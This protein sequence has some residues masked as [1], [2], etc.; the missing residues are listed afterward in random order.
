MNPESEFLLLNELYRKAYAKEVS[1]FH[2]LKSHGSDRGIFRIIS[3]DGNSCIGIINSYVDENKAFI[4]FA[5]HFKT[6][7]LNVPEVF[8]VSDDYKSYLIEDLGD[9]TLLHAL[10]RGFDEHIVSLYQQVMDELVRF[11]I[12]ASCGIDYSLCYQFKE[13]GREN[14]YYDLNYFRQAF[15]DNFRIKYNNELL[16][17]DFNTLISYLLNF[18]RSYFL[19]RDFQSR[20][21]MIKNNSPYFIDFQ[22]GRQGAFLYDIAS[23]IYDAKA[24]IPQQM[25]ERFIEYYLEKVSERIKI[26]IDSCHRGF[27]Y[28][29]FIRIMQA[30]GAYGYLG[31]VKGKREFLESVPKA[32]LNVRCLLSDRI[33]KPEL[34]Y[35]KTLFLENDFNLNLNRHDKT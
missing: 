3:L 11:Q 7:G 25:K 29:A 26:D 12:D 20:N 23:L 15:L 27:W 8:Y 4:G 6:K 2:R 13:F 22:S 30:M 16:E 17:K 10:A 24:N 32:L 21:I 28:F 18:K 34:S 9:V 19:Y 31:I 1:E 5:Q 14:M 33:L 35:L